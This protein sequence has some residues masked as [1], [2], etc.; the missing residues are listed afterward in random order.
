MKRLFIAN[1]GEIAVRIIRAAHSLNIETVQGISEPDENM[2]AAK[3]AGQTFV[4]GPAKAT[5]SYLDG[6]RIIEG[7]VATGCDAIHPGYGFL[8]ENYAFARQV[9]DAGLT[10]VGP[11]PDAI[12]R[13]GNKAVARDVAL[14]AGVQIVPGS[15]GTVTDIATATFTA[16]RI[17][18]P[19]LVKASAGGGGRGIRVA[20]DDAEL[21]AMV[22][23]A[24]SEARAA[25]GDGDVYLER[26]IERARHLEVQ[27]LA[28]ED[29]V[30]HVY[31]RDCSVQRNR[32]KVWE[33]APAYGITDD[34]RAAI[35]A[36]AVRIASQINYVGVGT[37]EFLF[38]E[39]T[40]EHYFIEMNTRVQV[41]HPVTEMIAGLDLVRAGLCIAKGER[42]GLTQSDIHVRGHAIEVRINAEDPL[43]QFSP[44]PGE[45]S[46]LQLPGGPGIRF[47]GGV[48]AGYRVL[49]YYD[50]LIGKLIVWGET[51]EIALGYMRQ[52]LNEFQVDGIA[53]TL[54]LH[55][56]LAECPDIGAFSV[57]INWLE[58]FLKTEVWPVRVE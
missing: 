49:P 8:S 7:A 29:T 22:S 36:A 6:A 40:R 39:V 11:S 57:H 56:R 3:L 46:R 17:G 28:D 34:E 13:M 15:E 27:I 26:F 10:F 38:D 31:E 43:T 52:A 4:L 30:L 45:I 20:S 21:A 9:A 1:R 37:V 12:A 16:L 19:V 50:S 24:S 44:A 54:P 23:L 14:K 47:D 5:R 58:Q 33:E 18:Y 32:Q 53:T 35:C 42:L 2:L 55:R 51:R 48:Y 41:E 25:F